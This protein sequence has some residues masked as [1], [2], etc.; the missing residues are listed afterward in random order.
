MYIY[1]YTYIVFL[2]VFLSRQVLVFL[3][4]SCLF[5]KTVK[6]ETMFPAQRRYVHLILVPLFLASFTYILRVI[7]LDRGKIRGRYHV[8]SSTPRETKRMWI[9]LGICLLVSITFA[10]C[11]IPLYHRCNILFINSDISIPY[12]GFV[13]FET[14]LLQIVILFLHV[15]LYSTRL[16]HFQCRHID[17]AYLVNFLI[18]YIY[19]ILITFIG[20]IWNVYM[21]RRIKQMETLYGW[22]EVVGVSKWDVVPYFVYYE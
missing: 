13:H 16:T 12:Y 19:S 22:E 9:P 14:S 18:M 15:F 6:F 17:I 5:R 7:C 8:N 10:F 4:T 11:H 2:F 21:K 1:I 20:H 3:F